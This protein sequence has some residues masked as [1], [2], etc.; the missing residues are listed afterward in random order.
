MNGALQLMLVGILP[1]LGIAALVIA[2]L[3]L[4][5][6]WATTPPGAS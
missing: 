1:R 3:W 4:G 6:A 5:Y 2:A